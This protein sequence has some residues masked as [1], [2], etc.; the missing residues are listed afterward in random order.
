MFRIS[1]AW[2]GAKF[3]AQDRA[4]YYREVTMKL[5]VGLIA[6]M[7]SSQL[8]ANTWFVKIAQESFRTHASMNLIDWNVGDHAEYDI[9]MGIVQGTMGMVIREQVNTN[10]WINQS[11]ALGSAGDH[12]VEMLINPDTGEMLE[13]IVD[14]EPKEISEETEVEII[15]TTDENV[16]VPA[17]TFMTTHV[18]VKE[19][20]SGKMSD[21]WVNSTEIPVF[22]LVKS[23]QPGQYG[24]VKVNLTGFGEA[25]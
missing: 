10:F 15:S 25:L 5:F 22:G 9:D 14:G 13:L 4:I 1:Q 18:V 3:G 24:K 2:F 11:L 6:L 19:V 21:S 12:L 16:T 23:V 8:M 17:G 7:F 20:S